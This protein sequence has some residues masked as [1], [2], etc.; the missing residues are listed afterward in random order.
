MT[1]G[2]LSDQPR[3]SIKAVQERTGIPAVTLRA[4]ERRYKLVKPRRSSGNY[5]LYSDRDV[6]VLRQIF[7]SVR[8]QGFQLLSML[9]RVAPWPPLTSALDSCDQLLLACVPGL[10]RWCRYVVLTLRR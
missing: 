7:P 4:W 10:Q 6:A 9:R 5:R 2:E 3:Y 1:A 8:M